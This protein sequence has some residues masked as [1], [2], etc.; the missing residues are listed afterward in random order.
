MAFMAS[1][2]KQSKVTT[3]NYDSSEDSREFD[4][5]LESKDK[6]SGESVKFIKSIVYKLD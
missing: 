5:T 6:R 4:V 3:I 1:P 2:V